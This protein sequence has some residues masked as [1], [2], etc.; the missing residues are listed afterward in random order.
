MKPNNSLLIYRAESQ[1]SNIVLDDVDDYTKCEFH[2]I[3]ERD[4]NFK[5]EYIILEDL[6]IYFD[7]NVADDELVSRLDCN[8]LDFNN[9]DDIKIIFDNYIKEIFLSF[10]TKKQNLIT[11]SLKNLVQDEDFNFLLLDKNKV[12]YNEINEVKSF[13]KE[14]INLLEEYQS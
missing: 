11:N 8:E 13:I 1:W 9:Q 4:K 3:K 7:I 10:S 5:L 14:V 6:F 12:F 2:K